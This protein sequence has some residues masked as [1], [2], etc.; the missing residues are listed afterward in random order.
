MWPIAVFATMLVIQFWLTT[1]NWSLGFLAGHE[2]RQTQTALSILFI[3]KDNNFAL[4][5][6]TPLF[7]PPWSIPM[8][9]PL[10][11]WTVAIL[12]NLSGWTIPETGR[13]VSLASFYLTLPGIFLLLGESKVSRAGRWLV[14]ALIVSAPVYV[15]Y[16]RAILIESM[17]LMLSV[18]FL[19]TFVRLCRVPRLG[20][21]ASTS[22][23][24]TAAILVKVTTFVPW[25]AIAIVV[26][27]RW[28]WTEWKHRAWLGLRR[29]ICWGAAAGALPG[30]AI[31]WWLR[32]ADYI[33]SQSPGGQSLQSTA[34]SDVNW[35]TWQ[36][37]ISRESLGA[38][39]SN[40]DHAVAPWWILFGVLIFG[41]VVSWRKSTPLWGLVIVYIATLGT[42]PVLYHRHDYYF[43][44]VAVFPLA[45]AGLA[46]SRVDAFSRRAWLGP[47][48]FLSIVTSQLFGYARDYAPIHRLVSYGGTGLTIVLRTMLPDEGVIIVAGQD[49]GAMLPYY[50]GR[51]GLMLREEVT[52]NPV[53]LNRYFA[54]LASEPVSA[55]I[56]TGKQ[57]EN[58]QLI[59]AAVQ[60]FDLNPELAISHE[61]TDVYLQAD[62]RNV[63]LSRIRDN[64][65]FSGVEIRG[66][67]TPALPVDP[68][69]ADGE[70]H[71]C[72]PEQA[73]AV[74]FPVSP[75]PYRYRCK[76]GFS[77]THG[78]DGRLA[79]GAHP[80]ADFWVQ[81]PANS[82][83]VTY[84][85]GLQAETFADDQNNTDGVEFLILATM[86]DG[87]T[88][89][90]ASNIL[91][92]VSRAEDR[93]TREF[94]V[95]LPPGTTELQ[96][97][98]RR[99]GTYNFDWAYWSRVEV[100]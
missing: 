9:F 4:A 25:C 5:Y 71:F 70:I 53:E 6:P 27:L 86:K 69:I 77:A 66:A 94:R 82:K 35:G 62:I 81:I 29:T 50:T 52:N 33:K 58:S 98:T 74:F 78:T 36:D 64:P 96:F 68:I 63:I 88:A 1:Y 41:T 54:P 93:Q 99:V 80:E 73:A 3:Q 91:D 48:M 89:T 10:Y 24:G 90:I 31:M 13:F 21:L 12:V 43:Y 2:F 32:Y 95:D 79:L 30:L 7:G 37:R 17:A 34:L 55:L 11:Q 61:T 76:F 39:L 23:L 16:S 19:W 100:D 92:P 65:T 14:L 83:S 26:G 75:I 38:L 28:S 46:I 67:I 97:S 60:L 42:F 22:L 84:V 18:W 59:A 57:R 8:E 49:W 56:L 44:A 47:V 87:T 40:N 45:A 72:T 20:W 15:F 85:V 51:R